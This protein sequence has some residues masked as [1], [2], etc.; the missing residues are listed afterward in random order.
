MIAAAPRLACVA[1][2]DACQALREAARARML[3]APN[4]KAGYP[5]RAWYYAASARLAALH[6]DGAAFLALGKHVEI[7]LDL[8]RTDRWPG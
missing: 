6:G 4:R 2:V 3:D 8:A 7:Y 5:A 1:E